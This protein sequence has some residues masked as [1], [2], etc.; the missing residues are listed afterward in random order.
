M[1][2]ITELKKTDITEY[3]PTI[4]KLCA[5]LKYIQFEFAM[6]NMTLEFVA[7]RADIISSQDRWFTT[8]G[9]F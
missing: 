1:E 9:W 2:A 8:L 3:D 4:H 6:E 5:M 7:F